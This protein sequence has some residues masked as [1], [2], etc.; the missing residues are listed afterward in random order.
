MNVDTL[1]PLTFFSLFL[2][3]QDTEPDLGWG[4]QTMD[5]PTFLG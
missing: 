3:Y 2:V 5:S 4:E 1:I